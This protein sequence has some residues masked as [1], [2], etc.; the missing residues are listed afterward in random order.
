MYDFFSIR[1]KSKKLLNSIYIIR[2]SKYSFVQLFYIKKNVLFI[3]YD[4]FKT[5][6]YASG[7]FSLTKR[8]INIPRSFSARAF[9][10][11]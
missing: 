1:I 8:L 9:E 10:V 11:I 2:F 6:D 7:N 5:L 3:K 4:E